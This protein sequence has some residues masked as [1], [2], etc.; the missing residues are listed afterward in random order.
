MPAVDDEAGAEINVH[1]E[2]AALLVRRI[3]VRTAYRIVLRWTILEV[4]RRHA[5]RACFS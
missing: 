1:L 4:I 3:S 5:S 2:P